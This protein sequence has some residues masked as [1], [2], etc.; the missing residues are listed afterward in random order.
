MS[1]LMDV[2]NNTHCPFGNKAQKK[3]N[4]SPLRTKHHQIFKTGTLPYSWTLF[5]GGRRNPSLNLG[6]IE[7]LIFLL[8]I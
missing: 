1:A 6:H 3:L 8:D 2:F 7:V 5:K 4:L